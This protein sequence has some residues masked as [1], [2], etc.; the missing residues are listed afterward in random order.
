[1]H[2]FALPGSHLP[3]GRGLAA[4]GGPYTLRG[5]TDHFNVYSED[6]LG[7]AGDT[8]A[9]GVLASCEAEYARLQDWFGG[10]TPPGLP[11][12]IYVVSGNFGAYHA[13]CAATELHCAAFAGDDV[14]LVRMLV[15]AEEVEVFEAAQGGGWDCG[16]SNGEGLSRILATE[17][18]PAELNGFA[19]A[20]SW[21]DT[22]DR[23][24]FVN[25]NDPTDTNYVSIGS[26]TLF[27]NWLR[28][29]LNY[30][31]QDII[32]AAAPTL[33]QTYTKL[34]GKTDGWQ[35]FSG[36]LQARF[37]V[38][39]PSGLKSDNPFPIAD[40]QRN[41]HP[42]VSERPS[43]WAAPVGQGR[44]GSSA[45]LPELVLQ[46]SGRRRDQ[47]LAGGVYSWNTYNGG[48]AAWDVI[49]KLLGWNFAGPVPAVVLCQARQ[50]D[51]IDHGW[52]DQFVIQVIETG[53]DFVRIRV[54]RIDDGT[55][56]S[57]WGQ[58]LRIDVLAIE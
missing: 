5:G 8:L 16:A 27:L 47:S 24:D 29:Q 50:S 2:V 14:D 20:A 37:P 40:A 33:A 12:N 18:Y 15:V 21:L 1:M 44:T 48:S 42:P 9:Q 4:D 10:L 36:L 31:W 57:G 19:S 46:P 11:F 26:S 23:P 58:N 25:R 54:R 34:T 38:G 30:T 32:A 35:Q 53:R 55:G 39:T 3:P 41:G 43:G 7:Q 45:A 49:W 22:P 6:S 56:G 17:L 28:Y 13:T 51:N 52:T